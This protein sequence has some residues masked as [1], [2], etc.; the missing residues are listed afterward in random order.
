VPGKILS[1][2]ADTQSR[3][4]KASSG[5]ARQLSPTRSAVSWRSIFDEA[6]AL[7]GFIP[8]EQEGTA[9]DFLQ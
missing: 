6:A 5:D 7:S 9:D 1:F 2:V 4:S 3:K 8:E